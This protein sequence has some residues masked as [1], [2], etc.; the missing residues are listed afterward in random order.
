MVKKSDSEIAREAA[1]SAYEGVSPFLPRRLVHWVGALVTFVVVGIVAALALSWSGII[2]LTVHGNWP[3]FVA[4]FLHSTYKSSVEFHG[5]R[6]EEAPDL[7][8]ASLVDRGGG[9]FGTTCVTCHGGP[10]VAPNAIAENIEPRPP[11]LYD[12]PHRFSPGGHFWLIHEGLAMSGMPAW[13]AVDRTDEV[14][15]MVAFVE[16]LPE[17]SRETFRAHTQGVTVAPDARDRLEAG[18]SRGGAD[19]WP[20][21]DRRMVATTCARCHGFDGK[22]RRSGAFPNLALQ[23]ED[24]LADMLSDYADG[25]KRSGIMQTVAE[26]LTA[27]QVDRLAAYYARQP[28]GSPPGTDASDDVVAAGRTLAIEGDPA[29][30]VQ[31]CA[32]CHGTVAEYDD[33]PY[34]PVLAGQYEEYL[35]YKLKVWRSLRA[36]EN[37]W[38]RM[39]SNQAHDLTDADIRAVSAFY[40]SHSADEVRDMWDGT[41]DGASGSGGDG[42]AGGDGTSDGGGDADGDAASA[43]G[44][45]SGG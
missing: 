29:R 3:P 43:N 20:L 13:P 44:A 11:R 22:G 36:P 28:A 25:T 1:K 33:Q 21:E 45:T 10:G 39:M 9:H 37:V 27:E 7:T 23:D 18:F 17:M 12:E 6:V 30:D 34:F 8:Q 40:A 42:A 16:E 2:P 24:Y 35:D 31:A 19:D 4:T 32:G 38:N 26:W 41:R 14:W 5:A 15:A